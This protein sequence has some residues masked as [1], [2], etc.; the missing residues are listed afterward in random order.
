MGGQDLV[1][2]RNHTLL[3]KLAIYTDIEMAK[4]SIGGSVG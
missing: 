4:Y 2:N 3:A 1:Q